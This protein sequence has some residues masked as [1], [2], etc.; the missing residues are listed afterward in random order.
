MVSEQ[1][2]LLKHIMNVKSLNQAQLDE[3]FDK[4][5]NIPNINEIKYMGKITEK[6]GETKITNPVYKTISPAN[7]NPSF[8][9]AKLTIELPSP[10][11]I[12]KTGEPYI[13][14]IP[15]FSTGETVDEIKNVLK[16]GCKYI[17]GVGKVQNYKV[18]ETNHNDDGFEEFLYEILTQYGYNI[19]EKMESVLEYLKMS[20]KATT[21]QDITLTNIWSNNIMPC[22]ELAEEMLKDGKFPEIN[23]VELQGLVYMPPSIRRIQSDNKYSLHTKLRIKR[24]YKEE[25]PM[26]PLSHE[27]DYDYINIIG[28]GENMEEMFGKIKQGYPLNVTGR[29]ESFVFRQTKHIIPK[30]KKDLALILEVEPEA[31]IINDIAEYF[32][33]KK[34][35]VE[36]PSYN[37]LAT[38][39]NTDEF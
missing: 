22:D 13:T 19:D 1:V 33:K 10:M 9:T 20:R 32:S 16:D 11:R 3:L 12:S 17:S 31:P 15:V 7:G 38:S 39:F 26:V 23:E 18:R 6:K 5:K 8:Q 4:H 25:N 29:L 2:F 35:L 37:V 21:N 34:I 14:K 30:Q 27:T 24:R 28:F 36:F